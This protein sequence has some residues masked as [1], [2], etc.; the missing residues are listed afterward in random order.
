[1]ELI[2]AVVTAGP[3]GYFSRSRRRGLLLYLLAWAIVFPVQT[4]VVLSDTDPAGN[5]WQY[6]AVN[7]IILT[8]GIGLNQL[9]HR[10]SEARRRRRLGGAAAG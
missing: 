4:I 6:W 1:M 10:L 3:L 9:G 2:T 5:D 7:A 8:T